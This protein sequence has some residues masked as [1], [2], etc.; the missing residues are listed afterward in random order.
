MNRTQ[1]IIAAAVVAAIVASG[2]TAAVV[3]G[4]GSSDEDDTDGPRIVQPGAP[5]EEGR[6]LSEDDAASI[7][8]PAHT[9]ADTRFM[10]GMIAH[11]QQ[12]IEMAGLVEAHTQN[13]DLPL[14]AERISV[15]QTDEIARMEQWLTERGEEV[16]AGHEGH[17]LMPGM[18]T[19]EQFRQLDD[20]SGV[21]FDRLFLQRMIAHHQGAL[22]MVDELYGAGGGLEP[23]A[24]RFAREAEADQSI[25]I[26][27]ME[28]LLGSL[29]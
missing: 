6:E 16:P 24:D 14:L 23:A 29:P 5:G 9:P 18:L 27:R 1:G 8:P 3:A 28:E 21:A 11:H 13:E 19:A 26:R 25:E 20:A 7:D 2:I 22:Q 10:Q 4:G 15:S 17:E 12:A